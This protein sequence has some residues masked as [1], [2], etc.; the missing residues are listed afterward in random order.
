VGPTGQRWEEKKGS[1]GLAL[2]KEN[3]PAWPTRG[4]EKERMLGLGWPMRE[5]KE[6]AREGKER[7]EGRSG[8]LGWAAALFSSFLFFSTLKPLKQLI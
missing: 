5:G 3:G 8:L 2:K 6:G 4:E 7:E 1:L